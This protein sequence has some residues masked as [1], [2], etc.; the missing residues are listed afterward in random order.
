[1]S[2]EDVLQV[3]SLPLHLY[4]TF[5]T[6]DNTTCNLQ[7]IG[8]GR[9]ILP[10]GVTLPQY[11]IPSTPSTSLT[12]LD[13]FLYYLVPSASHCPWGW[14]LPVPSSFSSTLCHWG[15]PC[16][17]PSVTA[18][19]HWTKQVKVWSILDWFHN[20][21]FPPF[22]TTQEAWK[23]GHTTWTSSFL[24]LP[25][26]PT[27]C[28]FAKFTDQSLQLGKVYPIDAQQLTCRHVASLETAIHCWSHWDRSQQHGRSLRQRCALQ[29][30]FV[31]SPSPSYH[32]KARSIHW[33]DLL[34]DYFH[35]IV[36]LFTSTV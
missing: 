9:F 6:Y 34:I 15:R 25:T 14:E 10:P 4:D 20:F 23:L 7:G 17:A 30:A 11:L 27:I 13:N 1:M 16:P 36:N 26:P 18:S 2:R 32:S 29:R 35:N 31:T 24:W 12:H 3:L 22:T 21:L 8:S 28:L 5:S 19:L 33:L